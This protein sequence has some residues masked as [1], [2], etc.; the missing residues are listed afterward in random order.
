MHA[1]L[2]NLVATVVWMEF[3]PA[4]SGNFQPSKSMY[5]IIGMPMADE[6]KWRARWRATWEDYLNVA[7]GKPLGVNFSLDVAYTDNQLY[8][9]V[10]SKT[11]DFFFLAP[12]FLTCLGNSAAGVT[13]IATLRNQY[14]EVELSVCGGNIFAR[15]DDDS[16]KTIK[17]S[18]S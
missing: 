13:P 11:G 17:V 15:A 4:A 1:F 5:K 6:F 7:V 18:S 10:E 9:A 3:W 16:I 8:S 2:L 12:T 14:E